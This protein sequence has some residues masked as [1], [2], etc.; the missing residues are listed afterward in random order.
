MARHS[1]S[2]SHVGATFF[3]VEVAAKRKYSTTCTSKKHCWLPPSLRTVEPCEIKKSNFKSADRQF[4][5]FFETG[6]VTSASAPPP[7][8]EKLQFYANCVPKLSEMNDFLK[9]VERL[10][11]GEVC[12]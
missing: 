7:D 6:K 9:E 5:D 12:F 8:N 2:C 1:S 4:E 3:A 11:Q 10:I